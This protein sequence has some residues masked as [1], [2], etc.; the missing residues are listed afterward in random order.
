MANLILVLNPNFDSSLEEI[1]Q[2]A[3]VWIV[4]SQSNRK[5]CERLWKLKPRA[6]HREI[7]AITSFRSARPEDPVETLIAILPQ[8]E[9][10][11]GGVE[12]DELVFPGR[13]VLEVIG[14][15]VT[16]PVKSALRDFRFTSFDRDRIWVF[17]LANRFCSGCAH[18]Q[19]KRR[20]RVT[21]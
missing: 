7:G 6:D 19:A 4:E 9:T 15:S 13:F 3:P 10:H 14:T 11:H 2:R 8:L 20:R 1:S 21:I 12:Q 5:A 17:A 16:E 18:T